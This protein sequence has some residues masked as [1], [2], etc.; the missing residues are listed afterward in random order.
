MPSQ[1]I[2][3]LLAIQE[4]TRINKGDGTSSIEWLTVQQEW[5]FIKP[6]RGIE[7]IEAQKIQS[8]VTHRINM[9]YVAGVTTE[10][11]LLMVDQDR[12]FNIEAALNRNEQNQELEIE[13]V[14][15]V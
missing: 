2:R 3:H 10:H 11:R 7:R 15:L 5:G 8:K 14:E 4:S 13:A 9:R 1:P 6:L 12:V